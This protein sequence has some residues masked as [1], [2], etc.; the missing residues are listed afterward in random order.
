MWR[1]LK[2]GGY[3]VLITTMPKTIIDALVLPQLY[4]WDKED[5]EMTPAYDW[6]TSLNG[7]FFMFNFSQLQISNSLRCSS[8]LSNGLQLVSQLMEGEKFSTTHF[9]KTNIS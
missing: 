5:N 6:N 9:A 4:T 3:L 7:K 2:L 8:F 1:T